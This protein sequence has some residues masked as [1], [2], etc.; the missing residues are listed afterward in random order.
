[1][2][3]SGTAERAC[4]TSC[5]RDDGAA[6][7]EGGEAAARSRGNP[8]SSAVDGRSR[9]SLTPRLVSAD[10]CSW[11]SLLEATTASWLGSCWRRRSGDGGPSCICGVQGVAASRVRMQRARCAT[12][13]GGEARPRRARLVRPP[14]PAHMMPAF[15]KAG[16]YLADGVQVTVLALVVGERARVSCS[17][18]R[19]A[20]SL[21]FTAVKRPHSLRACCWSSGALKLWRPGLQLSPLIL[22]HLISI[23]QRRH[24]ISAAGLSCVGVPRLRCQAVASSAPAAGEKGRLAAEMRRSIA[25]MAK[26][27]ARDSSSLPSFLSDFAARRWPCYVTWGRRSLFGRGKNRAFACAPSG[28]PF[29]SPARAR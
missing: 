23:L 8:S 5:T 28:A 24:L 15:L 16:L 12:A 6:G 29:W 19:A 17:D 1:M 20:A 18:R 27:A 14:K 26:K 11:R 25:T 10:F 3:A 9:A 2:C 7:V 4:R 22:S 21:P 13:G